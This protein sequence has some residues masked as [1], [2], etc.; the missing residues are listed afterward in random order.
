M[1]LE[2]AHL[3]SVCLTKLPLGFPYGGSNY[4]QLSN[5][6]NHGIIHVSDVEDREKV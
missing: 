1:L 2:Q 6:F 5:F 3:E 4:M